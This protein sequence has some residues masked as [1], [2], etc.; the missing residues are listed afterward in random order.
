MRKVRLLSALDSWLTIT[1][2]EMPD[3]E[4]EKA[5]PPKE[6]PEQSQ[7]PS[8]KSNPAEDSQDTNEE[9]VSKDGRRRGRRR[10]MKKRTVQDDEGYLVTKEEMA[11][12]S[13][14]EDEP[15]PK[16]AAAKPVAAKKAVG[17]KKGQ[18]SI[19]SFFGKK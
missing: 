5:V 4:P 10:V 14:S 11:W 16:K 1:D 12:E 19:M 2:E 17:G 15:A 7:E 6:S 18:G 9:V 8:Q 13:F 3:A